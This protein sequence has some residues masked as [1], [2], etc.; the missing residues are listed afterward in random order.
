MIRRLFILFGTVLSYLAIAQDSEPQ[1]WPRVLTAK[2]GSEITLYQ[3]QLDE[4]EGNVIRGRMAIS[5]KDADDKLVF[6]AV[7][8]EA[9]L[10]TDRE[11]GIAAFE[12]IQ[13]LQTKFPDDIPENKIDG[14]KKF[15]VDGI[16]AWEPVIT[17]DNLEASLVEFE[18]NASGASG[19]KHDAPEIFY[20]ES[21]AVLVLIDGEPRLSEVPGVGVAY[22]MNSPFF[23]A[24]EIDGSTFFLRGG[25]F[26]YQSE[27]ITSG[28]KE[29]SSV[30]KSVKEFA[31][32]NASQ[33][34]K[35]EDYQE[36]TEAPEIV[37]ATSAAELILID[38]KPDYQQ[39]DGTNLLFV[40][41]TENDVILNI[42]EQKHYILL[43]GRFYGS[44]SLDDG[45]WEFVEPDDLPEDFAKIPDE[46]T[47]SSIKSSVPG[48]IESKEALLDQSIPQTAEVD[49]SKILEV[50]YDGEPKFTAVTGTEV[51]YAENSPQTVL[52]IDGK[53]YAV[54][55]GIWYVSEQAKGPFRVSEE[56][57]EEVDDLPASCPVHNVK[58]VYI[59]DVTPQ[60][61]YVGYTPG[62][63]HSY[64]YGGVV[65]Y[66]TGWYYRPWYGAYYYP[67]PVTY[68]YGVHWN[69][70]TG[71][72][73]TFGV[74]YGWVGWGFHPYYRPYWGPRGYHRGYRHG[75]HHGYHRGYNA[76]FRAG[77]RAAQR[78]NIYR[79]RSGVRTMNHPNYRGS[80]RSR[81]NSPST[82]PA[83]R[84]ST[85]PQ[86]RPSTRPNDVLTDRSGNVYQRDNKGNWG[87][88]NR[89]RSTQRQR[90]SDRQRQELN[91]N[92]NNR[93]RINRGGA[94]TGGARRGG[95]R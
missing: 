53:Y 44:Q 4:L 93:Q 38:G 42:D 82:R 51:A 68:G 39:V 10:A 2:D 84:P 40:K 17:L 73:F 50:T 20:R 59:Y 76:G 33:E 23:I 78:N 95:R 12:D 66:G 15:L 32:S 90:P 64:V 26:W 74:S 14:L 31:D 46:E 9:T 77:Y 70:Y 83:T 79:N 63:Y 57:P 6:G 65:V 54:D 81:R 19:L 49:K 52:Q 62:Y 48:T 41:N 80:A 75:Y 25:S 16:S 35:P 92:Y 89:D 86:T 61:V 88:A 47:I 37:I 30:P 27:E 36:P 43:A 60:V 22:V 87:N 85:R 69:P 5:A 94:R 13:V 11:A 24:R 21:D 45:S 18:A 55:D 3:P 34:E 72:G 8:L 29:T 67:R 91:R 28:W 58:Y 7:F 56:R 1:E 71:W